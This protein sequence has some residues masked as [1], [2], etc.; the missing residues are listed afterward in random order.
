MYR[1]PEHDSSHDPAAGVYAHSLE[2]EPAARWEPLSHHLAEVGAR[3]AASAAP[4]GWHEVA[5]LAGH[6]HDIGKLSREF[7][8]YIRGERTSGGDHSSAGARVALDAY[9]DPLGK[10]L[11]A[12]IAAHHA[13]LADGADLVRRMEAFK[14]RVPAGWEAHSGPPP[15]GAALRP[16]SPFKQDG[17][18]KGFSQSFLFRMLFSCLVDADFLETERFYADARGERVLRG[19]HPDLTL[20]RDRLRIFMSRKRAGAKATALNALRGK[21]V[22]HAI[23]KAA[24]PPGLFTLTVPTGGGKTLASLSF[25]LEHA[26]HHGMRRV[27]YVIPFTSIIEQTAEVFRDAL[28]TQDD[29]LEHHA[30]F[31]WDRAEGARSSDDEG[32][33]GLLKLRRAV[34]NWDVPIVVTTAVQFFES[35]FANRP[36]RCRKLHNIAGSVVILDEAQTIPVDLLL[37]SMAALDELAR[38]YGASIVLC[39]ATQPALRGMDFAL[40]DRRKQ[41]IGFEVDEGRELAPEPKRLYTALKRVAVERRPDPTPDDT[42]AARFRE[43]PQMLCIVNSRRHA[44]DLFAA[45]RDEPGAAHLTTLMCPRHRRRVLAELRRRLADGAPVRLV[46]TSLIEAGVDI[47]F[48]EVWRAAAGLEAIAQAAGRCNREGRLSLGHVV[49]FEPAAA[50]PPHELKIRWQAAC[51]VLARHDDPLSLAAVHDYY[52]ELYWQKGDAALDTARVSGRPGILAAIADRASTADFPFAAISGAFRM[53]REAM[54]PVVVP[55]RARPDDDAADSLLTRIAAQQRPRAADLRGLQQYVVP[56]PRQARDA[57]LAAGVL[58]PVHAALGD[59]LL[60]FADA[61]NYDP[62]T[63]VR[64]DDLYFR[65]SEMNVIS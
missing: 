23:A 37:P 27:I 57:W 7:Q 29:V 15:P 43:Q 31:D 48:P 61:A 50:E 33:D 21:I 52:K 14:G 54:E 60:R 56:V 40:F 25:A 64:L 22:D 49:V 19:G 26:V 45:I 1:G 47:D 34:E 10:I 36:S 32:T 24:L 9:P 5:R 39:T 13:G 28:A 53:I 3:A 4:F 46:A 8:A 11:A 58:G 30:S 38:N 35:L 63:G 12:I 17:R 2:G 41:P 51:P 62:Q 18:N 44:R 65:S 55:W 16:T 42:I 59:R 20:L 6:L